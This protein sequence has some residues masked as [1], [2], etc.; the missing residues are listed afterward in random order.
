MLPFPN[1]APPSPNPSLGDWDDNYHDDSDG[2]HKRSSSQ[3][4]PLLLRRFLASPTS[5]LHP[6]HRKPA[7]YTAVAILLFLGYYLLFNGGEG[8]ATAHEK[9]RWGS[10]QNVANWGDHVGLGRARAGV[11]E[12]TPS[13][14]VD[15]GDHWKGGRG[16]LY[17]ARRSIT[18]MLRDDQAEED[19]ED[20]DEEE[21]EDKLKVEE[22]HKVQ[23]RNWEFERDRHGVMGGAS[24]EWSSGVV[25]SGKFL[26]AQVD[27]RKDSSVAPPPLTPHPS[28][29][30]LERRALTS[31]ILDLGWQYLDEEDQANS[32]DLISRAKEEG[33]LDSLPLRDR[34]RG[35]EDKMLEAAEGWSRIY[36]VMEGVWRKS[37]LEVQL[38]KMV[39]RVPVV[40]FSKTTCP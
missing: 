30:S 3:Q 35:D 36:T 32:E 18:E 27:M 14:Y 19:E 21:R 22:E 2:K 5:F 16:A 26:G 25:G 11:L 12:K 7:S 10:Q 31:H 8:A 23:E 40:I 4:L 6:Q 9:L 38:E 33:W 34:V 37:A 17:R 20:E 28:G 39:R 29:T 24:V 15:I 1:S 13:P